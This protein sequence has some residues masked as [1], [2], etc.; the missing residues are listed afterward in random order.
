MIFSDFSEF[1]LGDKLTHGG[2]KPG[3]MLLG[4]GSG[5][6]LSCEKVKSVK[7]AKSQNLCDEIFW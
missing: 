6:P 2:G 5:G 1:F 4:G 7:Y 3:P